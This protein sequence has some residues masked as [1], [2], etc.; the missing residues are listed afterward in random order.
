[1]HDMQKSGSIEAKDQAALARVAERYAASLD[2]APSH[3][4]PSR[5]APQ[6]ASEAPRHLA[7]VSPP[8]NAGAS[9]PAHSVAAPPLA[10]GSLPRAEQ[11]AARAS[12]GSARA[13]AHGS[14][15]AAGVS[16]GAA[17]TEASHAV[18][19]TEPGSITPSLGDP[20][21]AEWVLRESSD[22][23]SQLASASK[24][25]K[26][27][28]IG[29]QPQQPDSREDQTDGGDAA[30]TPEKPANGALP[31]P[32]APTGSPSPSRLAEAAEAVKSTTLN[33]RK[34]SASEI[35]TPAAQWLTPGK[36]QAHALHSA[37]LERSTRLLPLP[38]CRRGLPS[39]ASASLS[40][41]CWPWR[42]P[43]LRGSALTP[44]LGPH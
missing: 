35:S 31:A 21:A 10:G 34:L 3:P 12:D 15:A 4:R 40:I 19:R 30:G 39:G 41:Q 2:L 32:N 20:G 42:R 25:D 17:G 26:P 16:S 33:M 9:P 23:R 1:M 44:R 27:S 43:R 24:V 28:S 37:M 8:S 7:G 5:D 13:G 22:S 38:Q 18:G 6:T 11:P 36:V 14:A 29:E